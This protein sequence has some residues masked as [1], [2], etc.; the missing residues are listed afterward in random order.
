MKI[1]AYFALT[2]LSVIAVPPRDWKYSIGWDGVVAEVDPS[3]V[4]PWTGAA[5]YNATH[6]ASHIEVSQSIAPVEKARGGELMS[7]FISRNER[8]EA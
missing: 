5:K 1:W 2:T 4:I 8:P 3:W 7:I 6:P